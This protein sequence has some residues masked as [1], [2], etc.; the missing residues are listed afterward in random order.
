MKAGHLRL[1]P[2]ILLVVAEGLRWDALSCQGGWVNTPHLDRLAG[3]GV[4]FPNCFTLSPSTVSSRISMATGLYPHNTLAWGDTNDGLPRGCR[5]WTQKVR[6]AGYQGAWIGLSHFHPQKGDLRHLEYLMHMH[7]MDYVNEIGSPCA[8]MRLK[9]HMTAEWEGKG[10]WKLYRKD[11]EERR[12]GSSRAL[13]RPS[14]LPL[15]LY[16]DRYLGRQ[17]CEFLE[18]YQG[19]KPWFLWLGFLGPQSPWDAPEPYDQRYAPGDMPEA[20]TLTHASEERNCGFLDRLSGISF[21]G[22]K[23]SSKESKRLKANYAGKVALIDEE[24]GKVL[25]V[26]EKK[27]CLDNTIIIFTSNM[28]ETNGDYGL[29]DKRHFLDSVLRVPL[30]VRT[31]ETLTGHQRGMKSEG[32]VEWMDVGPTIVELAGEDLDYQQFG[33]SLAPSLYEPSLHIRSDAISEL[34]GEC[35]IVNRKWKL[36]LNAEGKPYLLFDREKDP[37]ESR[38]LAGDA[39]WREVETSLCLQ[40]LERRIKSECHHAWHA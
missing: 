31:P 37:R 38:N 10:V 25:G 28:G 36:A 39:E 5:T 13:I 29:L 20:L 6:D 21:G 11:M 7:G 17:A 27:D 16:P 23:V 12:E 18:A 30:I 3:E 34:L 32:F 1:K 4:R 35:V 2:N 8:N 14:P 24:I 22:K 33:T 40:I 15:D 9:S 19:E 26:L